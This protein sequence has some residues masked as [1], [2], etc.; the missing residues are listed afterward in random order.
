MSEM[1]RLAELPSARLRWLGPAGVTPDQALARLRPLLAALG[2]HHA[3]LLEVPVLAGDKLAWDAPGTAHRAMQALD[4]GQR[5][6]FDTT[7]TRLLSE[8]RRAAETARAR[9]EAETAALLDLLRMVPAPELVFAVDGAPVLAGWGFASAE[10]PAISVLGP[11]DDGVRAA[12]LPGDRAALW[13]TGG[14]LAALAAAAVLAAPLL[15]EV[16]SPPLPAC[17]VDQAGLSAL[18]ELEQAREQGRDLA[19]QRDALRR[20]RGQRQQDCPLP[21]PPAPAPAPEPPPAPLPVPQPEPPP[22]PAPEP[23]PEPVPD[24]PPPAPPPPPPPRA[25]LPQDRWDQGDISML[26]GC[27]NLDSN[28]RTRDIDTGRIDS[29]RTWQMCFDRNGRGRQTMTYDNGRRCEGPV[30]GRFEG[31]TL[32]IDDT[33][34][35]PCGDGYRVLHRVGRCERT[36]ETRAECHSRNAQNPNAPG[37]RFTLRR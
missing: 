21:E 31:R 34:D 7:L 15:M 35:L 9:G 24:P 20:A 16:L 1:R 25:D 14:A 12:A 26:N 32:V 37:S 2:P 11:F 33:A 36:S 22:Q 23:A 8:V 3:A 19:A 13:L 4:K 10:G 6:V 17:V 18:R 30:Q 5:A 28:Y 27:W 29:V